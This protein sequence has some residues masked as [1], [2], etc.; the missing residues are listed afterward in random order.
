MKRALFNAPN[1]ID[2]VGMWPMLRISE[3]AK[4]TIPP[5]LKRAISNYLEARKRKRLFGDLAPL[6]PRVD[7]MFEG[8]ANLDIFKTNGEEYFS[9]YKEI[10]SLR[11]EEK[12]L[13]V[14]CGIGRKT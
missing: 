13:D 12:M 7:D 1:P 14:G 2:K 10:C 5:S 11:P 9:I 6:V 4:R 8:P 3:A